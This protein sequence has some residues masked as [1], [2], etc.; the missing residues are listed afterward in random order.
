MILN[1]TI[2]KGFICL[3]LQLI[4]HRGL[5]TEVFFL[6]WVTSPPQWCHGYCIP[7]RQ[8]NWTKCTT[9]SSGCT[10]MLR[11]DFQTPPCANTR[12]SER[13]R[14][15]V[16]WLLFKQWGVLWE[17]ALWEEEVSGRGDPMRM[18]RR[19]MLLPSASSVCLSIRPSPPSRD[20]SSQRDY[21]TA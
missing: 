12:G 16:N 14:T 1:C 15:Q 10:Q 19:L 4:S 17:S 11:T 6:L 21:W 8:S 7:A 13:R 20:G 3:W 5:V 18:P 9:I 2:S